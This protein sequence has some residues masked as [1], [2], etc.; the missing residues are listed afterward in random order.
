M[1]IFQTP[2]N[3]GSETILTQLSGFLESARGVLEITPRMGQLQS[4]CMDLKESAASVFFF[5]LGSQPTKGY[6]FFLVN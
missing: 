5:A 2:P 4:K 3:L 6:V 1:L